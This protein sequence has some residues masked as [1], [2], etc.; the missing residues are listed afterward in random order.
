MIWRAIGQSATGTSHTAA[1]K[2]CEDAV[3]YTV[4]PDKGDGGTL[5]CCVSDGAGSALYA[6]SASTFT[7]GKVLEFAT[8]LHEHNEAI[9]ECHI[10]AMA[11]DIFYGLEQEAEAREASLDEFSCT[12]LGCIITGERAAFF[13][14]GDGAII[15]NDENGVYH[16]VWWPQ[17][18]EYHNTTSFLVEDSGFGNL[19]V[20]LIEEEVTEVALLTDGLQLLVLNTDSMSVHQPFFKGLFH[21]LR[22]ADSLEQVSMLNEK[23]KDYL[24]SPQINERTDDDKTLFLATRLKS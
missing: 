14:I 4:L 16:T 11:E 24:D 23:L 21:H 19:R 20:S 8:H 2:G 5:V 12:M 1:R 3:K 15:R 13:Q 10:Y 6:A 7:A 17:N 9:T 18:G 22:R